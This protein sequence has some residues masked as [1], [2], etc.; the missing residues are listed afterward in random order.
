M[1]SAVRNMPQPTQSSAADDP[2]VDARIA[3]I[4]SDNAGPKANEPAR[5]SLRPQSGTDSN[6]P[7]VA[8]R[9]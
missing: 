7:L 8:A 4:I 9:P 6:T 3:A 2:T 5:L 1:S